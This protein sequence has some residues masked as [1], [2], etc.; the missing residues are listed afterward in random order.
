MKFLIFSQY[1]YPEI[2]ASQVRLGSTCKELVRRGHQ[3]E[4]VT[5][6]PHYPMG[7]ISSEYRG[8][9]F[10]KEEWE[11]MTI[12]RF[13]IYPA[14]GCGLKRLMNCAS[15]VLSSALGLFLIR[16]KPDYMFVDSPPYF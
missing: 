8:R 9:V 4:I 6:F 14:M 11:G 2:G 12:Y 10:V 15:F 3:V 5:A 1:F 16:R 13:W 7:K